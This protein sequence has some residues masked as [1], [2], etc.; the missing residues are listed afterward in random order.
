M[1]NIVQSHH[2]KVNFLLNIDKRHS[3]YAYGGLMWVQPHGLFSLYGWA[4]VSVN[5][6]IHCLMC[7][8]KSLRVLFAVLCHTQDWSLSH[9]HTLP[10]LKI[11][12][13]STVTNRQVIFE[14]HRSCQISTG[15]A[16]KMN[17]PSGISLGGIKV[18][19]GS[20]ISGVQVLAQPVDGLHWD[21]RGL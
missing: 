17:S 6:R 18:A 19:M 11:G 20:M 5:E 21:L 1:I 2:N 7:Y 12:K 9:S 13:I 4:R 15:P 14:H 10:A 16:S 8:Q 3:Q